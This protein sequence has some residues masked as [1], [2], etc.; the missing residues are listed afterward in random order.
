MLDYVRAML[1]GACAIVLD[2]FKAVKK[3]KKKLLKV[4]PHQLL[5]MPCNLVS[6]IY[7]I[8]IDV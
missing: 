6:A 7:Y 5:A 8:K 3:K 4:L 2:K 1:Q